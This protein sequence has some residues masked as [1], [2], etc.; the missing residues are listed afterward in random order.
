VDLDVE[1]AG[2]SDLGDRLAHAQSGL[3][4][5]TTDLGA[6]L[7]Q[8]TPPMLVFGSPAMRARAWGPDQAWVLPAGGWVARKVQLPTDLT[9]LTEHVQQL[10][11]GS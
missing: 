9:T 7:Q 11:D 4:D 2:I 3:L 10:L 5:L 8:A 6:Q 1:L